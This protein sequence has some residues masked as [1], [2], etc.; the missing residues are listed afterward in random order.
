MDN[1]ISTRSASQ[2]STTY[3][4]Q[5]NLAEARELYAGL[6]GYCAM[7]VGSMSHAFSFYPN[8]SDIAQAQSNLCRSGRLMC[9]G[10]K[11]LVHLGSCSNGLRILCRALLRL[12]SPHRQSSGE[13]ATCV[14]FLGF[15]SC[16]LYCRFRHVCTAAMQLCIHWIQATPV[17]SQNMSS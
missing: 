10:Q 12:R 1:R 16:V 11:I 9:H 5:L 13:H 17:S 4:S 7:A 6:A 8:H 2:A 14:S 3:N 15:R